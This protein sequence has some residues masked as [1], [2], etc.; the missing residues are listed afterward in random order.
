MVKSKK[1]PRTAGFM[2][3]HRARV[4]CSLSVIARQEVG[5]ACWRTTARQAK[6]S[7]CRCYLLRED[8]FDEERERVEGT[9]PELVAAAAPEQAI[10]EWS[11]AWGLV[12]AGKC[13]VARPLHEMH[14]I[15]APHPPSPKAAS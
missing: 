1:R 10:V 2:R 15:G 11:L 7:R 12:P 6:R 14:R 4:S 9:R 3:R 13:E 5:T 8:P